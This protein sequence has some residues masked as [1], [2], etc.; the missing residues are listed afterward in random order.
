M[1]G[2]P[3]RKFSISQR[4]GSDPETEPQKL[5]S[6][7]P[8]FL[9]AGILGTGVPSSGDPEAGG[10]L[11]ENEQ[12]WLTRVHYLGKN[13]NNPSD[14]QSNP[15]IDRHSSPTIDR[16]QQ[17]NID[18]QPSNTKHHCKRKKDKF[19]NQFL[20]PD[21]FGIFKELDGYAKAID[22]RTLHVS[23]EDIADILQTA[24]GADNLF[25]HHRN[26]PEQK[27]TKEF[28]DTAGGIHNSFIQK[29]R[30]PTQTSIDVAVP[31]SVDRQP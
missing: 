12:F 9:P 22:G 19:D 23:R 3:Y 1:E 7:E 6:G 10:V 18:R 16:Q 28:Y 15:P 5:H 21:E 14:R 11:A 30:H 29:S 25:M 8:G 31:T 4:K 17:C 26:N 13:T 27:A 20:T 24:N 2:S